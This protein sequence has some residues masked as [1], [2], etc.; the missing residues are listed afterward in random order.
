M[1][2]KNIKDKILNDAKKRAESIISEAETRVKDILENARKEAENVAKKL[3]KDAEELAKKEAARILSLAEL[4]ERRKILKEKINIL[5]EVFSQALADLKARP[6]EEYQE[7]M[8]GLLVKAVNHGDEEVI[9]AKSD[10]DKLDEKFLKSVNEELR[11]MGKKGDLKLVGES[12]DFNGGLLLRKEKIE[13]W[14]NLEV[15]L[16]MLKD[17]LEIEIA[18]LL[19][20]PSE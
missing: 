5:E 18:K 10:R 8:K 13:T 15:L 19:F 11:K 6:K 1:E 16:E 9:V 17:D 12:E 2:T 7:I 14:C 3:E 4:E 20:K